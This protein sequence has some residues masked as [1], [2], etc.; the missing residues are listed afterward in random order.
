MNQWST[1]CVLACPEDACNS[2]LPIIQLSLK[3]SRLLGNVALILAV[4]IILLAQSLQYDTWNQFWQPS[5]A[6]SHRKLLMFP[7]APSVL[8]AKRSTT[9][10][11]ITLEWFIIDKVFC[12]CLSDNHGTIQMRFYVLDSIETLWFKLAQIYCLFV[13]A[14][15]ER[16]S[17]DLYIYNG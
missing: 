6:G 17:I 8:A 3:D 9:S 4:S 16:I 14:H 15:L 1:G 13:W 2:A 5:L 10:I 11:S 7:A 12:W